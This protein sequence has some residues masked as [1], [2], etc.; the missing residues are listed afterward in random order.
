LRYPSLGVLTSLPGE[1][2][3]YLIQFP[4]LFNIR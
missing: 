3:R 4:K 2:L 1:V